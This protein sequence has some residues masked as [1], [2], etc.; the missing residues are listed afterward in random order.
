MDC[1]EITGTGT[2]N[3]AGIMSIDR[4]LAMVLVVHVVR[5][6]SLVNRPSWPPRYNSIPLVEPEFISALSPWLGV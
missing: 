5:P 4:T 3:I 6:E 2:S 1:P